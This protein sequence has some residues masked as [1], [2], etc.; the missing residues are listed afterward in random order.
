[1][2]EKMVE[3]NDKSEKFNEKLKEIVQIAKKKKNILEYQEISDAFK[4]LQL[5]AEDFEKIL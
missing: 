3:K 4:E 2:E 1:M 5:D